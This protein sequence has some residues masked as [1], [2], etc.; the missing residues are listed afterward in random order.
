MRRT[1]E[2]RSSPGCPRWAETLEVGNNGLGPLASHHSSPSLQLQT[3]STH[4]PAASTA[5]LSQASPPW[6]L[7]SGGGLLSSPMDC[8]DQAEFIVAVAAW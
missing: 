3:T 6:A 5:L 2:L 8:R 4:L 7:T 1:E